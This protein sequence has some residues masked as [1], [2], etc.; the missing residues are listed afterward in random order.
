MKESNYI[1]RE[2]SWLD[3]NLRVLHQSL[4]NNKPI[5]ER[6]KFLGISETNLDEFI[7]VRMASV[8]NKIEH[9][10]NSKDISGMTPSFELKSILKK[11]TKFKESQATTF[12]QLLSELK[13]LNIRLLNQGDIDE[14]GKEIDK[15]FELIYPTLTP[16]AYDRTTDFPFIHSSQLAVVV[17]IRDEDSVKD[18]ISVV[19]FED[20]DR[21]QFADRKN[22]V[23][24]LTDDIIK[25]NIHKI[26]INKTIS[27]VGTIRILRSAD[28]ELDHDDE[29]FIVER[30]KNV[31]DARENGHVVTLEVEQDIPKDLL[32]NLQRIYDVPNKLVFRSSNVI[33]YSFM[34]NLPLK[35]KELNYDPL[36]SVMDTSFMKSHKAMFSLLEKQGGVIFNHPYDSFKHVEYFINS[37]V[38]DPHVVAIRQT[39]YRVSSESS[40]IIESLCEASRRGKQVSV[41][42]ELKARFDEEQNIALI[43]KLKKSGCVVIYGIEALKTHCKFCLIVRK[44]SKGL[45]MYS[46][47][48]TG[49]YNDKTSRYYTDISYITSNQ[50]IG[51]DLV[52]VFNI[53]SG[54]SDPKEEVEKLF[55]S[56]YNI[57]LK[58]YDLIDREIKFAKDGKPASITLKLN[59]I[60]DKGMIDKLYEASANGVQV[61]LIVRGICSMKVINKNIQIRSILGQYLEHSRIYHFHNGG[62]PDS[63]ISSADL[64]TRNLDRRVEVMV[65]IK[66][67]VAK[68][69]LN[70][71]LEIYATHS[72]D[73]YQMMDNGKFKY[74]K[75]ETDIQELQK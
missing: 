43:E 3:F 47:I 17:S 33:D 26:F 9:I 4:L 16:I 25:R 51:R 54:V 15:K 64:L 70:N 35:I 32:K 22:N 75:T 2:L 37:A 12:I 30:M 1:N 6:V 41:L 7:S 72:I 44:T 56:P 62:K 11:I 59:S 29:S 21:V 36:L 20:F 46:H 14:Y 69:K 5:L 52:T 49:N 23:M 57:R 58:L 42:I 55:F 53:L 66:T 18:I 34:N 71:L 24:V 31:L 60:S 27:Y 67:S 38:N 40:P 8:M 13:E 74:Y 50:K 65:P 48:G 10:P 19:P 39:L 45:K 68:Y 63:F 28:V 73:R 61:I